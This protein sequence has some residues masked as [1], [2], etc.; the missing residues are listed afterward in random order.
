MATPSVRGR[1][2]SRLDMAGAEARRTSLIGGSRLVPE[3]AQPI[4]SWAANTTRMARRSPS[5]SMRFMV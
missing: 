5:P 4:A 2:P 1:I 3:R